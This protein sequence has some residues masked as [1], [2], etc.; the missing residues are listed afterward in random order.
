MF[1]KKAR[2]VL[3]LALVL[4]AVSVA[5]IVGFKIWKE[6]RNKQA[7]NALGI[8]AFSGNPY[9]VINGNVPFFDEKEYSTK[10]F[11][12][13][14]P[15]DGLGRCG[16]A[17]ANV[18][19]DLM[20]HE[21]RQAIGNIKPTGWK[22]EKYEGIVDSNPPYLYNRCHLIAYCLTAENSNE[23]NLITGTR[24]MNIKGMLPFEE[25]VAR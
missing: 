3:I 9:V 22:Q 19:R 4:M 10:S 15:L 12:K 23:K 21:E 16:V 24:Y 14:S 2:I 18:G 25:K 8:P 6:V 17:F 20:P 11:E 7:I 13:Y 1:K 5:A